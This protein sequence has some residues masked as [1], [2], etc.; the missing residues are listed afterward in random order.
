MFSVKKIKYNF[1]TNICLL[2]FKEI[3]GQD[4]YQCQRKSCKEEKKYP[5]DIVNRERLSSVS[6]TILRQREVSE[7]HGL[8][9]WFPTNRGWRKSVMTPDPV[10]LTGFLH[11]LQPEEFEKHSFIFCRILYTYN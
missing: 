6:K 9:G 8:L 7:N 4:Y 2:Y 10:N 5:Q 1:E 11:F 3:F